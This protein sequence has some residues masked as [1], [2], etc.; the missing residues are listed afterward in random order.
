MVRTGSV[1][2]IWWNMVPPVTIHGCCPGEHERPRRPGARPA[3]YSAA[4]R[5][6]KRQGIAWL[7]ALLL[8]LAPVGSIDAQER[9]GGVRLG[10]L[11]TTLTQVVTAAQAK[12]PTAGADPET[13][14]RLE[15]ELEDLRMRYAEA[16]RTGREA[17]RTAL[18]EAVERKAAELQTA[19]AANWRA[20]VGRNRWRSRD[21][22]LGALTAMIAAYGREQ[23]LALIVDQESGKEVFRREGWTGRMSDEAI[24]DLTDP[25]AAWLVER[26]GRPRSPSSQSPG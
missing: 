7:V 5:G 20:I 8:L 10:E 16:R 3:Q 4:E 24:E 19:Y 22:R 1:I 6:V 9:V 14:G 18:E 17:E 15:T 12:K 2:R 11:E 21:V 13:V 25:I 26:V 23:D